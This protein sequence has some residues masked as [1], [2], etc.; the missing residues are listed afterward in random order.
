MLTLI[1]D[2]LIRAIVARVPNDDLLP[3]ALTCTR[4]L[5]ACMERA[6]AKQKQGGPLWTTCIVASVPRIKWA[7]GVSDCK[8]SEA[9]FKAS[10]KRGDL[11]TLQWFRAQAPLYPWNETACMLKA[12]AHGHV[13]VL[14]WLHE[15]DVP[16][17]VGENNGRQPMHVAASE[18]HLAVVQWLHEQGVPL[19]VTDDFGQQVIHFAALNA[20]LA[21]VQW[22]YEQGV[23]L[24]VTDNGGGQPIHH[25][26]WRGHLD[27]VQWLYEQ[28]VPLTETDENGEQPMHFAA[29]EGHL[30][31]VQW[32][33][34]RTTYRSPPTTKWSTDNASVAK[35]PY[36]KTP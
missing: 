16:L 3:V 13:S 5:A 20:K 31:V 32:L 7:L 25:A 1:D 24:T 21:V 17:T 26:A 30:D 8:P 18:G 33:H 2:D 14:L 11:A 9:W 22:L 10:A 27:V 19:A 4:M 35:P 15:Q 36:C 12:A 28:G 34:E 29:S 6:K 23:L